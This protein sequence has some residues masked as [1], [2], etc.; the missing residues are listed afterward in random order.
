MGNIN[1]NFSGKRNNRQKLTVM[2]KIGAWRQTGRYRNENVD[3]ARFTILVHG[4]GTIY[5]QDQTII[6]GQAQTKSESFLL[7]FCLKDF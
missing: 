4:T 3:L 7:F 1:G 5:L 2:S 6:I